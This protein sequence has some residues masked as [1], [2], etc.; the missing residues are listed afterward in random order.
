M[1][2]ESKILEAYVRHTNK[3]GAKDTEYG[4]MAG[5]IIKTGSGN[6]ADKIK[7]INSLKTTEL[8]QENQDKFDSSM[9]SDTGSGNLRYQQNMLNLELTNAK[10]RGDYLLTDMH[11]SY[12]A[13]YKELQKG[14]EANKRDEAVIRA[15]NLND[16][17]LTGTF[18]I[19]LESDWE[20]IE[21]TINTFLNNSLTNSKDT[22]SKTDDD[23]AD[24]NYRVYVFLGSYKL[25]LKTNNIEK[26]KELYDELKAKNP[27]IN[28]KINTTNSNKKTKAHNGTKQKS[29]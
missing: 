19:W 15:L 23:E 3:Y 12:R 18:F 9:L 26:A 8:P 6:L 7:K 21:N 29:K 28:I 4:A 11:T 13:F 10:A 5:R 14:V 22:I 17:D 20:N 16:G 1:S 24:D 27:D 2:L 25:Q